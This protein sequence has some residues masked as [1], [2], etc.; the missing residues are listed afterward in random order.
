MDEEQ[1]KKLAEIRKQNR[2]RLDA[3]RAAKDAA[4]KAFRD[5]AKFKKGETVK[6]NVGHA[7]GKTGVVHT[8]RTNHFGDY[9][10]RVIV[11]ED[12]HLVGLLFNEKDL[13]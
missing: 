6:I 11:E 8:V 5:N 3:E 2:E 7:A 1:K 10:Y 4:H 12:G 13:D 9:V